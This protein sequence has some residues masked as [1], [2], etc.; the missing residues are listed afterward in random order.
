MEFVLLIETSKFQASVK[1]ERAK[2]EAG[3]CTSNDYR[4]P[5]SEL[6]EIIASDIGEDVLDQVPTFVLLEKPSLQ[7]SGGLNVN[8][9]D[10]GALT[11]C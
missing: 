11:A 3:T 7:V 4:S 8:M 5:K 9:Y 10:H 6:V 2:H 1:E